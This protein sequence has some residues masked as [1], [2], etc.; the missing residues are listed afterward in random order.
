MLNVEEKWYTGIR[1]VITKANI[2]KEGQLD[3]DLKTRSESTTESL[4]E[5]NTAFVVVQH[6]HLNQN[7]VLIHTKHPRILLNWNNFVKVLLTVVITQNV[8]C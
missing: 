6:S 1:H 4:T 2:T 8:G 7:E 5:E 3:S